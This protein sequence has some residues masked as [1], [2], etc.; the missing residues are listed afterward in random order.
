MM[1]WRPQSLPSSKESRNSLKFSIIIDMNSKEMGG[2]N[3]HPA[4][5]DKIDFKY[6]DPDAGLKPEVVEL[7]EGERAIQEVH[8]IISNAV[9][10]AGLRL[11]RLGED[12]IGSSNVE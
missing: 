11:E 2:V 12:P 3:N 4:E 6:I 9:G 1:K 5:D 8:H 10:K 7:S